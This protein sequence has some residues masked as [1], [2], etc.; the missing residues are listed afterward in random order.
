MGTFHILTDVIFVRSNI[1]QIESAMR[2]TVFHEVK[3][4]MPLFD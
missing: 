1:C 2:K 4:A 3:L